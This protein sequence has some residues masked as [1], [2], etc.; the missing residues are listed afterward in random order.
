MGGFMVIG[1]HI[2]GITIPSNVKGAVRADLH[3]RW[4]RAAETSFAEW[5]GGATTTAATGAYLDASGK[6]VSERVALV[7]SHTTALNAKRHR[8]EVEALARRMKSAMRQESVALVDG[9][10]MTLV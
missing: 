4:K 10:R 6:I 5:F 9:A 7:Q 3:K 8:P 2:V 1:S